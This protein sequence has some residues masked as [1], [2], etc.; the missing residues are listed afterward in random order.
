MHDNAKPH[1]ARMSRQ[2]L[3]NRKN[4][5]VLSWPVMSPD[6]NPNEHIWDYLGR[7]VRARGNVHNLWDLENA[8]IQEWNLTFP[9]SFS[10]VT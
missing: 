7:K 2:F 10:D 8:L 4:V 3:L 5:N 1:V 6:M 9:K